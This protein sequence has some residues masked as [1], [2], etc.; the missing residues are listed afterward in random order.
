MVNYKTMLQ[1]L[2]VE[3]VK[4]EA[5]AVERRTAEIQQQQ[6]SQLDEAKRLRELK[7]QEALER[8]RLRQANPDYFKQKAELNTK[9]EQNS[10]EDSAPVVDEEENNTDNGSSDDP[11][12]SYKPS[13]RSKIFV[14]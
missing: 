12:R 8:S 7:K 2:M 14:K 3:L 6:A 5:Q 4:E 1:R 13:S 9:P 11:F 10:T